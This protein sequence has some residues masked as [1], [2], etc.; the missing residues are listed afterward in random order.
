MQ[1][2]IN[3]ICLVRVLAEFIIKSKISDLNINLFCNTMKVSFFTAALLGI[4]GVNNQGAQAVTLNSYEIVDIDSYE[5]TF[6]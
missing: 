4:V 5:Q 1:V 3:L 6:S 2:A